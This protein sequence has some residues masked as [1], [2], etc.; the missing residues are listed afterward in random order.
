MAEQ[1]SEI[2]DQVRNKVIDDLI[3]HDSETQDNEVPV[4]DYWQDGEAPSQYLALQRAF[5]NRLHVIEEEQ[6][7]RNVLWFCI[8]SG[9]TVACI[10]FLYTMYLAMT[11]GI[12]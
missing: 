7:A 9:V 10:L 2:N 4:L 6:S 11:V 12:G 5:K 8:G 1:D 3:H